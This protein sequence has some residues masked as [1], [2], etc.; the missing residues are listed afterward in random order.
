[1][2][3][4]CRECNVELNNHNWL[5]SQQKQKAYWCRTCK[6]A[7]Q[8]K[9]DAKPGHQLRRK[10]YTK[11]WNKSNYNKLTKLNGK[12]NKSIPPGVYCIKDRGTIIYVGSSLSPYKR[13][14]CHFSVNK[15]GGQI[16]NSAV[17]LALSQG[18]IERENLT[19]EMLYYI[20]DFRERKNKEMELINSLFPIYN[21][22]LTH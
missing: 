2:K 14:S 21:T 8:K 22:S 18:E 10:K 12:L 20:D 13:R 9:Q 3:K 11:V 16:N 17:S 15:F 1:M 7:Y 19:F 6:N 5:K 4:H